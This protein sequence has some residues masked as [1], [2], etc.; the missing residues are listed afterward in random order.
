MK[1]VIF[2][3]GTSHSGSTMLDMI[4]AN[5]EKGFSLGEVHYIFKPVRKHHYEEID[6]LK[7][8]ENFKNIIKGGEKN[9]YKNLFRCFPDLDFVVDSSKDPFW[10]SKQMKI[11][12]ELTIEYKNVLIYKTPQELAHSFAKRNKL[13]KLEKS[14]KSY[15]RTYFYYIS[16]FI[17]ISYKQLLQDEDAFKRLCNYLSIQYYEGKKQ[18]WIKNHKTFFGSNRAR[19]HTVNLKSKGEEKIKNLTQ[20][21]EQKLY[22]NPPKDKRLIEKGKA[23]S[24]KY[25]LLYN[26]ITK[27]NS[28]KMVDFNSYN[29]VRILIIKSTSIIKTILKRIFRIDFVI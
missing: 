12:D 5:D 20:E 22:Y 19:A 11:L 14:I 24:K 6:K 7:K 13:K 1:K 2:V 25:E 15:Y 29:N 10:I 4:L 9:L 27:K 28:A 26:C 8:D 3:G 16:E 17:S 23:I 21:G 18:Y